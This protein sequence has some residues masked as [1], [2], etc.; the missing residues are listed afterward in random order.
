MGTNMQAF[1][2][3]A[4]FALAAA[5][6]VAPLVGDAIAASEKTNKRFCNRYAD[7][8]AS[9]VSQDMKQNSA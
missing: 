5:L 1:R 8:M 9:I 2:K 4:A 6:L 3:L 7:S